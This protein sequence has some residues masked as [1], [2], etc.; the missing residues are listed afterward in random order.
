MIWARHGQ[1]AH[2]DISRVGKIYILYFIAKKMTYCIVQG[3]SIKLPIKGTWNTGRK[4]DIVK[5]PD[6]NN[7]QTRASILFTVHYSQRS[8]KMPKPFIAAMVFVGA[9]KTQV[10]FRMNR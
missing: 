8:S 1:R 2:V 7:H 6:T 3:T 4:E 5:P 10:G 9:Q